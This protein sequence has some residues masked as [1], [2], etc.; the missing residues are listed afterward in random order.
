MIYIATCMPA[1]GGFWWLFIQLGRTY[2]PMMPYGMALSFFLAVMLG[3]LVS[4]LVVVRLPRQWV[5]NSECSCGR[6]G[7]RRRDRKA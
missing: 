2:M 6:T 7:R 4:T 3:A 1:A 5:Y